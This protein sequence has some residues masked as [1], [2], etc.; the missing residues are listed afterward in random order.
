M[1]FTC[2]KCPHA[3]T[4]DNHPVET[5]A[6][7]V[8]M[9]ISTKNV[10]SPY[11]N[12]K[13]YRVTSILFPLLVAASVLLFIWFSR[14]EI[15]QKEPRTITLYCFSAMESVMEQALLPAFQDAWFKHNQERV[16]FITTFAGS[17]VI[18]RQII[19]IDMFGK[20]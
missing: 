4:F 16:E 20:R 14:D 12:E 5:G 11:K 2:S 19:T 15:K 10:D 6:K 17:G 18:T 3:I 9:N 13:A 1:D 7:G 8:S